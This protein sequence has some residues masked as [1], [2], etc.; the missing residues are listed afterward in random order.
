M[1]RVLVIRFSALGDVAMLVPILR[2][3]AEQ[4]PEVEFTMLSQ[5]RFADLFSEMPANVRFHGVDLKKQ[6][7][8]EIVARLGLYDCVADMH[9]VLR[10]FYIRMALRLKGAKIASIDKGRWDK[11]R[12]TQ[13]KVH[14]PLKH[15]TERYADVFAALDLPITDRLLTDNASD[16]NR[17]GVGI[18]PFAAHQ[19]KIYPIE[20]MERVVAMLSEQGEK[21]ILFGGGKKEQVILESWAAKYPGVESIAGKKT[22]REELEIMRGLRVMITM[23]S[24]NMH[25]ASLVGTRVVSIW[26]ATHPYAGFLGYGQRERD[27]IQRDLDCRPCS[28]YG[29]KPCQFG[30]YR[31]MDI[32]PE[33]IVERVKSEK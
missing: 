8:H 23:D 22:M 3:A 33:E 17:S 13:G 19:G 12:L 1:K 2:T 26:G 32:A 21:V 11:R 9:S 4:Y 16:L 30:D 18:A 14:A 20:R 15:T 25:L 31:C 10:S 7:L 29:N 6:S 24:G 5:Q 28:I 27:C